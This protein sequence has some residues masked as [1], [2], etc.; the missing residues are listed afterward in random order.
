M[1]NGVTA[2]LT[3]YPDLS[4]I[5]T[6][7]Y[8]RQYQVEAIL[9]VDKTEACVIVCALLK[10]GVVRSTQFGYKAPATVLKNIVST[11]GGDS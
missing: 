11:K 6:S 10:A 8:F 2:L 1:D 4:I 9:G 7:G 3:K 5:L